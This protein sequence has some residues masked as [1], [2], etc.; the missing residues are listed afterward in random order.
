MLIITEYRT[1]YGSES[2][3][4]EKDLET[5]SSRI[6]EECKVCYQFQRLNRRNCCDFSV[7][8]SCLRQYYA[9]QVEIGSIKIECINIQCHVLVDPDEVSDNLDDKLSNVYNRLLKENN[10]NQLAKTCPNC[11]FMFTLQSFQKLRSM[12]K[13]SIKQPSATR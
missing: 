10:C 13:V 7:C 5:L 2:Q 3:I 8:D 1:M 11:C 9:S 6:F 12:K 4:L